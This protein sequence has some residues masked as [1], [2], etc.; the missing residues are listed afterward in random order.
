MLR[1]TRVSTHHLSY[2]NQFPMYTLKN[3]SLQLRKPS[4]G[5]VAT[6]SWQQQLNTA[7]AATAATAGKKTGDPIRK[8]WMLPG[9]KKYN[10]P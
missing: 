1:M 4:I 7:K 9:R 3:I 8:L 10:P 2:I 6:S 5:S